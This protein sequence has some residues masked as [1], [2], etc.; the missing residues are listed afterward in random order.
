MGS[1]MIPPIGG[2]PQQWRGL[3][4]CHPLPCPCWISWCCQ[5]WSSL[6]KI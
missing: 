2:P 6:F 3:L 5:C 1:M 4:A